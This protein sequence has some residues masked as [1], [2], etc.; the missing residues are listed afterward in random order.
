MRKSVS[1]ENLILECLRI[2]LIE[3][4]IIDLYPSD[5]IQSPVHLSIGQEAVA[6]GVSAALNTQ[7]LLFPNYRGH[8]FYL[9]RGGDLKLFFAELMGRST[10]ISKG[11][12]GSMHLASPHHGVMG[13]SAVVASSIPHAVGAALADKV[14]GE[15]EKI[16]LAV[17]GDGAME[18]GVFFESLNFASLHKLNVIFLCEDNSLA[19]HTPLSD[20]QSF[21]VKKLVESFGVFFLDEPKGYD[22]KI[23][24]ESTTNAKK[25]IQENS[26]PV[27]LRIKT[28]RYME[29]VGP[30]ED[31]AAGYRSKREVETW[32]QKDPLEGDLSN[33]MDQI[34]LFNIEIDEAVNFGLDSPLSSVEELLTDVF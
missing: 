19:V 8:A 6:V 17:F 11:K 16:Y 1:Y 33:F 7:D 31:F 12:A 28:M 29:H 32:K 24:Y 18:Q 13:A 9:A 23:V 30:G 21:D 22:P 27:F 5:V 3:Q 2:R 4:K 25:L 34:K 10:G 26:G 15:N 20:R 14:R